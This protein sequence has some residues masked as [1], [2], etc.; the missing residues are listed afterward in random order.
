MNQYLHQNWDDRIYVRR[1]KQPLYLMI[2]E[3]KLKTREGFKP[4]TLLVQ[5]GS[6]H[7]RSITGGDGS[8]HML[9]SLE[10]A[11][12]LKI[13]SNNFLEFQFSGEEACISVT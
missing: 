8:E 6:W 9:H 7:R 10:S 11:N 13:E 1:Q 3:E 5:V 4:Q 2:L 12:Y